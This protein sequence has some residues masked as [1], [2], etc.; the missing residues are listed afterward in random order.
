MAS[1]HCK[2]VLII[3]FPATK[4]PSLLFV[5]RETL[6]VGL[7]S[8]LERVVGSKTEVWFEN[9]NFVRQPRL[10]EQLGREPN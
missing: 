7:R 10:P 9:R 8:Q 5:A 3:D 1:I 4:A 2:I 6:P